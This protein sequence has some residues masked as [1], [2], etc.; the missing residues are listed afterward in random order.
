MLFYLKSTNVTIVKTSALKFTRDVRPNISGEFSNYT[1]FGI[2]Q[3][4]RCATGAFYAKDETKN[5]M[6]SIRNVKNWTVGFDASKSNDL[7]AGSTLQTK[8]VRGLAI[9]KI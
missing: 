7:Y 8:A 5:G 1:D 3:D 6:T 4:A 2:V 9:I